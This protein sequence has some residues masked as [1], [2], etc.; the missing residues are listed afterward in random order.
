VT[1]D[2]VLRIAGAPGDASERIGGNACPSAPSHYCRSRLRASASTVAR[3]TLAKDDQ[4][5]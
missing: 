2:E 1:G 3:L 5:H 4:R